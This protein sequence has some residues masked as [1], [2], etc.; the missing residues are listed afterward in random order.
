[1]TEKVKKKDKE[2][3]VTEMKYVG[4]CLKWREKGEIEERD[5]GEGERD[6]GETRVRVRF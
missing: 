1:M 5:E 4:L 2:S 6:G 3:K